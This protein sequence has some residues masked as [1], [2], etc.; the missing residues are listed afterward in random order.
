MNVT[1]RPRPNASCLAIIPA[2]GGSKRIPDKNIRPFC[3]RP[4]MAHSIEAA[5]ATGLFERIMVSTDSE[6]IAAVAL[7]HGAE[8]PF[9]REARLSDDKAG[10]DAVIAD[11]LQR[12]RAMGQEFAYA[13]CLFATAALVQ[14]ADIRRGLEAMREADARMS[15]SVTTFPYCIFRGLKLDEAGRAVLIWPEN[16]ARHSQEFPEAFHDA[17]Q[18]F[19]VDTQR[20]ENDGQRFLSDTV[21]V[22]LPRDRV[23]DID[24]LE[25]WSRAEAIYQRLQGDAKARD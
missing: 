20:F 10:I 16:L 23:Q 11:V 13:C 1:A 24:T 25:D 14:P 21:P 17:G 22:H 2:R 18:F 7:A 8:L 6:K 4:I 3:G 15:L 12:Y 5:R 9:L 19:W